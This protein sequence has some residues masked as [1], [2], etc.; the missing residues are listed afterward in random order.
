MGR[1][2][3]ARR[4][5]ALLTQRRSG[6]PG[7]WGRGKRRGCRWQLRPRVGFGSTARRDEEDHH[8]HQQSMNI[9]NEI[10]RVFAKRAA[11]YPECAHHRDLKCIQRSS[12]GGPLLEAAKEELLAIGRTRL[13]RDRVSLEIL[14]EPG[15]GCNYEAAF[16]L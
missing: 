12:S 14:L 4:S 8:Q 13:L 10:E 5:F 2:A 6:A 15:K 7:V 11:R 3:A 9:V 16:N 1:N